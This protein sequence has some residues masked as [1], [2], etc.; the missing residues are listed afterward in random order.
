MGGR[1]LATAFAASALN[2]P[3]NKELKEQAYA[4][5]HEILLKETGISKDRFTNYARNKSEFT[6]RMT[7]GFPQIGS[8]TE[9]VQVPKGAEVL[10]E[11]RQPYLNDQQRRAVLATTGIASGYPVLDD[12]EGWGRLNL[13]AAADGYGAFNTDVTVVMDAAKGGFN[14]KDVWRNDIPVQGS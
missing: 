1:V 9:A 8:T 3:D 14:A 5:A 10:L 13:F 6:E 4:Q 7:Y 2:D 11:T 12:P